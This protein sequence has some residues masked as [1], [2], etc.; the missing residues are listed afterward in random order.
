M[1]LQ[2]DSKLKDFEEQIIKGRWGVQLITDDAL[3]AVC[4]HYIVPTDNAGRMRIFVGRHELETLRANAHRDDTN[5]GYE[6]SDFNV[7]TRSRCRG[8]SRRSSDRRTRRPCRGQGQVRCSSSR[9][10]GS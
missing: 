2:H 6:G 1:Y 3:K 4:E 5:S 9:A 8:A 10:Q 7:A